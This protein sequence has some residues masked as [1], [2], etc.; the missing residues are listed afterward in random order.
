MVSPHVHSDIL[1]TGGCGFLG[2]K[3]ILSLLAR[4]QLPGRI[5]VLDAFPPSPPSTAISHDT[6]PIV[7][8][9]GS[10]LDTKVLNEVITSSTTCIYHL[11]A[12]VS[13]QAEQDW[14]LG[15]QVNFDGTRA[16]AERC[17]E[18]GIKPVVV[19]TS[20]LAVYGGEVVKNCSEDSH[21]MPQSSYG[22][23]KAMCELLLSDLSRRG[24]L[25][26]RIL[27]LPTIAIR[28]GKPNAAASVFISGIV[29]E[30]LQHKQKT[31]LPV[32]EK[33]LIWIASPRSAIKAL[34]HASVVPRETLVDAQGSRRSVITLPGL[35]TTP[36]DL[37]DAMVRVG[38]GD[39]SLV[40]KKP[41]PKIEAIVGTWPG[42]IDT[43]WAKSLGFE[44]DKNVDDIVKIFVE[45]DMH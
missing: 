21:I 37:I 29:R 15:M 38:G 35:S 44:V 26:A 11:A 18:L 40:E 20:S 3:L 5:V 23:E 19:F 10:I 39:A 42:D 25:D 28:P 7:Y 33:T 22:A 24:L 16:I 14:N 9:T 43:P 30:P 12:V 13:A 4:T 34:V 1:I 45:D 36:R 6:V 17:L 41:D 8:R 27:R 32:D 31:V 2:R